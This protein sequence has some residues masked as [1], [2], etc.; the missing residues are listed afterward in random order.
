M[1]RKLLKHL[2]A[3]NEGFRNVL[4]RGLMSNDQGVVRTAK[5]ADVAHLERYLELG[6]DANA[7]DDKGF[8]A[9]FYATGKGSTSCVQ[10]L[11]EAGAGPDMPL[12]HSTTPLHVAARVNNCELVKLLLDGGSNIDKSTSHGFT[13]LMVAAA[14]GNREAVELLLEHGADATKRDNDGHT[15]ETLAETQGFHDVAR[16][17]RR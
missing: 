17:L 5:I 7:V 12:P 16:L 1:L 10:T 3:R 2:A 14:P 9:L 13:P 11:L 6:G 15:A 4:A 8:S